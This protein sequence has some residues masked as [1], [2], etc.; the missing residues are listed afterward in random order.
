MQGAGTLKGSDFVN[1]WK[2]KRGREKSTH[3]G[4][5]FNELCILPHIVF[6]YGRV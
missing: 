5:V 2:Q 1:A 3:G 4:H 6:I